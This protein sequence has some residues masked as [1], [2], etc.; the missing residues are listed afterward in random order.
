MKTR[1]Y[2]PLMLSSITPHTRALYARDLHA[3]EADV[4]WIAPDR[5]TLFLPDRT[6][7]MEQ[8][9]EHTAFFREAGFEV[10][11]WIQAFGFGDGLPAVADGVTASWTKLRS[12]YGGEAGD[13]F[14]PED[15]AFLEVYLSWVRD[16]AAC[17]PSLLMLD[18]D[19]CQSVRPG[20]GCYCHRHKALLDQRLTARGL[21]PLGEDP[22]AW[23]DR[24][25]T[26]KGNEDR[27]VFFGVMGDSLRRFCRRVRDTVDEVDPAI[28][29]GF[30]AGYTSWDVEGAP[31]S[32]LSRILAGENN[33]PFLRLTGAPYW[34]THDMQ[35]FAGQRLNT[36]IE[37]ARAQEAWCRQD[38]GDIEIFAEA[39]SYP[40]PRY[41]VASAYIDAFD[42]ACRAS[43]GMGMLKYVFDYYA[44]PENESGY[45]KRHLR[46][47]TQYD[48]VERL[49]TDK[50]ARGVYV[51]EPME[52]IT[53]MTLPPRFVGEG[54]VMHTAFSP[55]ATMLSA[56][57]IPT[58]YD[59]PANVSA[60]GAADC[61]IA[62]GDC[63]TALKQLP[64]KLILDLPAALRLREAGIDTGLAEVIPGAEIPL[65]ERYEHIDTCGLFVPGH[66]SLQFQSAPYSRAI[67]RE[68]AEVLSVFE[69][70]TQTF[71]SAY[72]YTCG[73]TELYVLCA[74]AYALR[75]NCSVLL[76]YGRQKQLQDFIGSIPHVA[77]QPCVYT[78]W[79]EGDTGGALL[80][81]NLSE[82]VLFDFDIVLDQ[83]YDEVVLH[84]VEGIHRADRIRVTGEVAPF[85]AITVEMKQ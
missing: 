60:D 28:R 32:E 21:A 35:R 29:V 40:R 69:G 38:G 1:L 20:L 39:D 79:K 23:G 41:H 22:A 72:R 85:S 2:V 58:T 47:A 33:K 55:A 70:R 42:L 74:D 64:K 5:Y 57:S 78:L 53:D 63:V 65:Y 59:L 71:P 77:G 15:P 24:F 6:A 18:D 37:F 51:C 52:K 7:V 49:F 80:V 43:G 75:P 48:R 19:L 8:I 36:V 13:A 84:G 3:M 11:L 31:A 16:M 17:A 66:T 56:L 25:L 83:P 68:G 44:D 26:G 45:L 46:L 50:T 9:R 54:A 76:S 81:L 14:C 27:R 30:C 12:M 73:E 82:D 34:V 61:A 10:G 67:L 62:F 4:V